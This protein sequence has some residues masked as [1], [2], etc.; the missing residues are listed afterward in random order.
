MHS[1]VLDLQQQMGLTTNQ[2]R[3]QRSEVVPSRMPS[4]LP[5]GCGRPAWEPH[6]FHGVG[7]NMQ[8]VF[9]ALAGKPEA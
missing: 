9:W 8:S 3:V 7:A 6:A 4:M 2:G 5:T 1:V